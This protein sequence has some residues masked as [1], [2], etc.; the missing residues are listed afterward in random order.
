LVSPGVL[1]RLPV[2]PSAGKTVC[3]RRGGRN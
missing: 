2:L 1:L 3:A